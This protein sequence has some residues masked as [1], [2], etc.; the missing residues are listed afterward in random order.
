MIY[1]D[2][3]KEGVNYMEFDRNKIENI[4]E[5]LDELSK[6][7]KSFEL[8]LLIFLRGDLF[9]FKNYITD[10]DLKDLKDLID[11]T[12]SILDVN[13]EDVDDILYNCEED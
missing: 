7:Y 5:S 12:D 13:K 3:K 11:S 8:A 4:I 2:C 6:D 10:S 1:Y 9:Q